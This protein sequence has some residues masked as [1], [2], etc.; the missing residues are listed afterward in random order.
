VTASRETASES[1][2]N[3]LDDAGAEDLAIARVLRRA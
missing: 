1:I 2:D 3:T